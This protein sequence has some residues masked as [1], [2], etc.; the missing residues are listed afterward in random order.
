MK[1]QLLSLHPLNQFLD[2]IK[3]GVIGDSR[4]HETVMLDLAGEF[5]ALTHGSPFQAGDARPGHLWN[6]LQIQSH[7]VPCSAA[8]QRQ[9]TKDTARTLLHPILCRM[10]QR[11][12]VFVKPSP[13]VHVDTAAAERAFPEVFGF[14]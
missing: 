10:R 13:I 3:H 11:L 6:T 14:A 5:D 1:R 12:L 8:I 7:L 9:T 4:R 2:P